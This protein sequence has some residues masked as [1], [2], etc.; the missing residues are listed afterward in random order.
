MNIVANF[1][2][3][4]C[5]MLVFQEMMFY[6]MTT[7]CYIMKKVLGGSYQEFSMKMSLDYQQISRTLVD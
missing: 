3:S 1:A 4:K 7:L 5:K 6:R 2:R